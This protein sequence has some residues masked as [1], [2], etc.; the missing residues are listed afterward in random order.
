MD[1]IEKYSIIGTGTFGT[2]IHPGIL[3]SQMSNDEKHYVSKILPIKQAEKEIT[4]LNKKNK[5]K[6]TTS[7]KKFNSPNNPLEPEFI[8]FPSY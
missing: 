5:M 8:L 7:N 6:K 3:C 2:V 1:E 4:L